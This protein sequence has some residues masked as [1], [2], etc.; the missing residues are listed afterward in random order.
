MGRGGA[1]DAL[2]RPVYPLTRHTADTRPDTADSRGDPM[3][4]IR[5]RNPFTRRTTDMPYRQ[6]VGLLSRGLVVAVKR[7]AP[8]AVAP[9]EPEPAPEVE[10]MI[11][12]NDEEGA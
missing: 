3:R 6:A 1:L 2:G 4:T 9:V 5:V 7:R 11:D 10:G 12:T 8:R